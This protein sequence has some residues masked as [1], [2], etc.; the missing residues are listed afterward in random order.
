ME[1]VGEEGKGT[2]SAALVQS[3]YSGRRRR[4]KTRIASR[5]RSMRS[6]TK[7]RTRARDYVATVGIADLDCPSKPAGNYRPSVC[8]IPSTTS[9][10]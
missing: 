3:L 7:I 9:G 4:M 8:D 10:Q 2:P 5:G 1:A 6:T